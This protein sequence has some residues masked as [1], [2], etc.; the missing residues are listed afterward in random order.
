MMAGATDVV[1][2]AG[3]RIEAAAMVVTAGADIV[4]MAGA[5]IEAAAMVVTAGAN[6]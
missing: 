5:R 1:V 4:V 6:A 2:M 3:A